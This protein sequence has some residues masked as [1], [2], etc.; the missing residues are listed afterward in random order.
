M[1]GSLCYAATLN[2]HRKKLDFRSRKCIYIGYKP[3]VKGHILLDL[4]C[5]ELFIYRDMHFFEH[6][7]PYNLNFASSSNHPINPTPYTSCL[8]YFFDNH[9]KTVSPIS[10]PPPANTPQHITSSNPNINPHILLPQT[11]IL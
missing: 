4:H 10:S 9:F 1:F 11:T 8:D 6:I 2:S 5:K 7:F 3:G